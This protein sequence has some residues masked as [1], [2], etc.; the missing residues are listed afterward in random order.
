MD[1]QQSAKE[2]QGIKA[3]LAKKK[4][5]QDL[6]ITNIDN[7]IIQAKI[8][9]REIVQLRKDYKENE[10]ILKSKMD[11]EIARKFKEAAKK[12]K[13]KGSHL[14]MGEL[15]SDSPAPDFGGAR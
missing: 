15:G 5:Y 6:G 4:A 7:D 1:M 9:E 14:P 13:K 11:N 3:E 8:A 10:A 2:M 12:G